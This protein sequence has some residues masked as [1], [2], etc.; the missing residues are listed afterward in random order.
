MITMLVGVPLIVVGTVFVWATLPDVTVSV[1][2]L[3]GMVGTSM[4]TI[5]VGVPLIVVGAV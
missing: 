1:R 5:L 2:V 3:S 4:M